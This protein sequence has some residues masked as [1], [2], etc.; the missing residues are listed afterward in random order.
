M[1]EVI[2]EEGI[3]SVGAFSSWLE[4]HRCKVERLAGDENEATECDMQ[5]VLRL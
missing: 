2:L 4:Y 3:L 1:P 5:L